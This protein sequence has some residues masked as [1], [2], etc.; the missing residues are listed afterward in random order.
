M[1]PLRCAIFSVQRWR[2]LAMKLLQE[3]IGTH[4]NWE[5]WGCPQD[6]KV[7]I[8]HWSLFV[9]PTNDFVI[10]W[11]CFREFPALMRGVVHFRCNGS[12]KLTRFYYIGSFRRYQNESLTRMSLL[13]SSYVELPIATPQLWASTD[14]SLQSKDK[15]RLCC[16]QT[17]IISAPEGRQLWEPQIFT[18]VGRCYNDD[19]ISLSICLFVY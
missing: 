15:L 12:S 10:V 2:R 16:G 6:S 3:K 19:N 11:W 17:P 18:T 4:L 7:Y 14:C 9:A 13:T 8:V 5:N 1:P